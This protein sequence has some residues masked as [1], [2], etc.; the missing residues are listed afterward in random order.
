[1]ESDESL[2]LKRKQLAKEAKKQRME[3]AVAKS[4]GLKPIAFVASGSNIDNDQ[5]SDDV[6]V[7]ATIFVDDAKLSNFKIKTFLRT[8][9]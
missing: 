6:C 3:N 8:H 9:F 5:V 2:E 1:M 7:R 4:M